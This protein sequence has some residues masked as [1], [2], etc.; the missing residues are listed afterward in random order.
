MKTWKLFWGLGFILLATA[1]VL[2]AVGILAPIQSAVG[3][4][5]ML[6][7]L[8]ALLLLC[9][10]LVRLF[11]GKVGEIFVPL[12]LIFMI[13][14][15]N[16]AFVCRIGDE[17]GNII[18]NWLLFLCAGL[19]WIGFGILFS[20]IKR[21][22]KKGKS[23]FEF[24]YNNNTHSG[25]L[26]SSTRYIDCDGF[27]YESVENNLGS[28]RIFFGNTDKYEGGGV[29]EIENNLG[30]VT[31]NVPDGWKVLMNIDNSLGHVDTPECEGN[32]PTLTIKGEN[33]LGNVSIKRV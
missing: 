24:V 11:R 16:I 32:D 2:D 26:G 25:S 31:V 22:K 33:N 28:C 6:G 4:I 20:G 29:L 12:A 13:F 1:L 9:Y 10:A 15:K 19:L 27:K 8:T 23:R 3:D 7:A 30:S 17:N 18:N 5:S 14:E 21:K